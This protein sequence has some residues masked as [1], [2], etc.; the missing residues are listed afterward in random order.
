MEGFLQYMPYNL[1]TSSVKRPDINEYLQL[2]YHAL[3]GNMAVI[4]VLHV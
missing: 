2:E 4:Q 3:Y 1:R